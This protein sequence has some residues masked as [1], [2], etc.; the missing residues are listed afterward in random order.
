MY[1]YLSSPICHRCQ[2]RLSICSPI[3]AYHV[4]PPFVRVTPTE[5]HAAQAR[6]ARL[7][8]RGTPGSSIGMSFS[9]HTYVRIL[10][11][12][13]NLLIL[14]FT[15]WLSDLQDPMLTMRRWRRGDQD[16]SRQDGT[17]RAGRRGGRRATATA[18]VRRSCFRQRL[19]LELGK[20]LVELEGGGRRDHCGGGRCRRDCARAAQA[21]YSK[22]RNHPIY[23]EPLCDGRMSLPLCLISH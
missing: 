13:L 4:R 1:R 18:G 15:T 23:R 11:D 9:Q 2:W 22:R 6:F 19:G 7:A 12:S 5:R 10:T 17:V 3:S 20:R 21:P 8:L 16:P 14:P